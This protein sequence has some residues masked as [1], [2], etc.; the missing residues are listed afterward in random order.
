MKPTPRTLLRVQV[1]A[2]GTLLLLCGAILG[3]AIVLDEDVPFVGRGDGP[4]W[5]MAPLPRPPT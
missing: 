1:G 2:W 4:G 5:I 3:H